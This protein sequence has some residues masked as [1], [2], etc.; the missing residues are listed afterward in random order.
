MACI[1]M[2]W[3]ISCE[4]QVNKFQSIENYKFFKK[5]EKTLKTFP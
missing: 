4:V 3:D 5:M 1:Q 2:Q